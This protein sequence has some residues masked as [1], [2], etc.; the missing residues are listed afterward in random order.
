M[1]DASRGF[2][3]A[4]YVNPGAEPQT[5]EVDAGLGT[6]RVHAAQWL[7]DLAR[8]MNVALAQVSRFDERF[9]PWSQQ[10]YAHDIEDG[11]RV[12][13]WRE[14]AGGIDVGKARVARMRLIELKSAGSTS[15]GQTAQI[16]V[17][18]AVGDSVRMYAC[19]KSSPK[20]ELEAF[21]CAGEKILGDPKFW[22]AVAL[23]P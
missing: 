11:D 16:V 4:F 8:V 12:Y 21:T 10:V 6:T 20:W 3:V 2:P 15:E 14:P 23:T 13:K 1:S 18:V 22:Q 19:E 17:E 7:A 9:L 5:V